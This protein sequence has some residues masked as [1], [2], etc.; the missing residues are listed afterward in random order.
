MM[1]FC[2]KKRLAKL[3]NYWKCRFNKMTT[4]TLTTKPVLSFDTDT[5][6]V[7]PGTYTGTPS[8]VITY[9]WE[10]SVDG[11]TWTVVVGETGPTYDAWEE[12]DFIRVTEV[13]D[14]GYGILKTTIE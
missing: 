2:A 9:I 8:P 13:A 14:N 11:V 3:Y 5:Y 6:T 7:T 1:G 12:L 10:T 4:L